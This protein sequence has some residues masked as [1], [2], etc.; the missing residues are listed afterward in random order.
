MTFQPLLC[1][2][3]SLL[4][5]VSQCNSL[6]KHFLFCLFGLILIIFHLFQGKSSNYGYRKKNAA[7][8]KKLFQSKK[9]PTHPR[10]TVCKFFPG[11]PPDWI[12]NLMLILKIGKSFK[13][14]AQNAKKK[15][16]TW[17]TSDFS[18]VEKI[19]FFSRFVSELWPVGSLKV[20]NSW[21]TLNKFITIG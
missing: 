6:S 18:E 11:A 3:K 8:G 20:T 17:H 1:S 15:N 14:E 13:F 21:L 9:A 2:I 10:H 12:G 16:I 4:L 7:L 5:A 19:D